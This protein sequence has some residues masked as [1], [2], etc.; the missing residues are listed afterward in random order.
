MKVQVSLFKSIT[1][2]L[3]V[4]LGTCVSCS[5]LLRM[6]N[7]LGQSRRENQNTHLMFSKSPP[8]KNHASYEIMW[9]NVAE[10]DRPKMTM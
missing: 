9:K 7:G 2:T 4:D 10:L 6:R 3:Y 8:P 5:I 1:G